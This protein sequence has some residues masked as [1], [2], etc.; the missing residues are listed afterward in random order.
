MRKGARFLLLGAAGIGVLLLSFLIRRPDSLQAPPP[1]ALKTGPAAPASPGVV[2]PVPA[3]MPMARPR[4]ESGDPLLQRWRSAIRL[5][6]Q[7]DVID[8]QSELIRREAEYRPR[9]MVLAKEDPEPRVRA[10][11][12]AVLSRLKS[13]PPEDYFLERAGDPHE[14]PRTSALEALAARGTPA[15]LET[16]DRLASSDPAEAVRAAA[17]KTA[18]AVRSR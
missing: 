10:F 2:L 3:P 7:K 12:V 5:H 16:V 4:E 11:T 8:T 14:Y 15:C 17:A 6:Q 1:P 13:P 9:L 18:K